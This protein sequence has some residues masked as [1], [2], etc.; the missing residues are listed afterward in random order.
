VAKEKLPIQA[1]RTPMYDLL[2][3]IL[4]ILVVNLHI[5]II[6]AN[7]ANILEPFVYYAVPLFIVMSFFF[8]TKYFSQN[9]LAFSVVFVRIKR[10]LLPLIIWSLVGF[11]LHVDK[12]S[13]LNLL[14]QLIS[15]GVVNVPLYYLD[16]LIVFTLIYWGL[17]RISPRVRLLLYGVIILVAF[18]LQYSSINYHFFSQ[19]TTSLE[20]CY[21][22]FFE[23]IPYASLGLFFGLYLKKLSSISISIVAVICALLT[24][25][26]FPE[27]KGF[28]YQGIHL[29]IGTSAL[30][31]IT[32]LLT[33]VS[34]GARVN[35]FIHTIGKYSFGVYL[36]HYILLEFLLLLV[37]SLKL[38][39]TSYSLLFLPFFIV[40][41]YSLCFLFQT[42][43]K[44]KVSYLVE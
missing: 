34:F 43:T 32:Y 16:L 18:G 6:V 19:I 10:L 39:I 17:T 8:M 41:C 20:K 31:L 5:R 37:P 28:H 25:V 15:G 11:I 9:R 7:Q 38:V 13:P 21:G 1:A 35:N 23:L 44:R 2:R 42:V 33:H 40:L 14:L 26:H 12:L 36:F 22:R 3:V 27:P 30:F 24:F 4:T 29:F